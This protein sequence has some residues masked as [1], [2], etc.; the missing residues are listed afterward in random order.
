MLLVNISN[1]RKVKFIIFFD[2]NRKFLWYFSITIAYSY[3]FK[4]LDSLVLSACSVF[5]SVMDSYILT[6][7]STEKTWRFTKRKIKLM[8][9]FFELISMRCALY[10][11][12]VSDNPN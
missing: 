9:V 11:L 6:Q 10:P 12:H 5:L 8:G 4:I 2:Y 7:S 1:L 3:V